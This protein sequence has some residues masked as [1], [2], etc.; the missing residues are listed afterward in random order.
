MAAEALL[1]GK[2]ETTGT[3]ATVEAIKATVTIE[4]I[5]TTVTIEAIVTPKTTTA[6]SS[7]IYIVVA[8]SVDRR[9]LSCFKMA[10]I[11]PLK[12]LLKIIHFYNLRLVN[13]SVMPTA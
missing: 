7:L 3:T 11:Q 6:L 9:H 12:F 13:Q 4:A 10:Y 1:L 5:K 2:L 8:L